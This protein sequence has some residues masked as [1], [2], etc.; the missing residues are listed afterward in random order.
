MDCRTYTP[1]MPYLRSCSQPCSSP[2]VLSPSLLYAAAQG[3]AP[4]EASRSAQAAEVAA[5]E[6]LLQ[7]LGAELDEF[8][9]DMNVEKRKDV[10]RRAAKRAKRREVRWK[11]TLTSQ[12]KLPPPR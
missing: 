3:G 8:G 12:G 5:E 10:Q 2:A 6:A 7:G 1:F 11:P 4:E 9:R